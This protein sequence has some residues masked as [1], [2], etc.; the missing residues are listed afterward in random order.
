[1][2]LLVIVSVRW[3]ST[4]VDNDRV[5]RGS[6][7]SGGQHV[8]EQVAFYL[9]NLSRHLR[10]LPKQSGIQA[11]LSYLIVRTPELVATTR[12]SILFERKSGSTCL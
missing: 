7:R 3:S 6:R 10:W 2:V 1:M 12:L 9:V 8:R 5:C 11:H 4:T